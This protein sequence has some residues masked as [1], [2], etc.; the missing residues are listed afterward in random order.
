MA[1]A[2]CSV[3]RDAHLTIVL[4]IKDDSK[5]GDDEEDE[6]NVYARHQLKHQSKETMK[7]AGD[8]TNLDEKEQLQ[9]T[10]RE[11]ATA[12]AL[13]PNVSDLVEK[14][15]EE[16]QKLLEV[17]SENQIPFKVRVAIDEASSCPNIVRSVLRDRSVLTGMVS[18]FSN[19]VDRLPSSNFRLP[20]QGLVLDSRRWGRFQT[21]LM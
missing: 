3:T 6:T 10:A 4:S 19:L 9:R 12:K 20:L 8:G 17:A 13:S 14:C 11:Q 18:C 7:P 21:H 2:S 5:P 1:V 15:G 16:I